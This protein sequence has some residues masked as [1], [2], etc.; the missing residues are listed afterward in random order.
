MVIRLILTSDSGFGLGLAC[1]RISAAVADAANGIGSGE[2]L[3]T[4]R[5][6]KNATHT[7][8]KTSKTLGSLIDE[9]CDTQ[10]PPEHRVVAKQIT[11]G[12]R[13]WQTADDVC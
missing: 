3:E 10:R 6:Q 1:E 11:C 8:A 13:G 4:L 9:E 12:A 2:D 7:A 5:G